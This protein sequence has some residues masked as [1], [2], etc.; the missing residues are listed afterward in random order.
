MMTDKLR[1]RAA[2]Y[3]SDAFKTFLRSDLRITTTKQSGVYDVTETPTTPA[4]H[5]PPGAL[6]RGTGA[7]EKDKKN[8]PGDNPYCRNC[9]EKH[10][11]GAHTKPR[12]TSW[13]P[14]RQQPAE[15]A[16]D[17]PGSPNDASP[18]RTEPELLGDGAGPAP[19][20]ATRTMSD[21]TRL[22]FN[23]YKKRRDN[24]QC[25]RCGEA[26]HLIKECPKP[27]K[28]QTIEREVLSRIFT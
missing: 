16:E 26:G 1:S 2:E 23:A 17:T 7:L 19:A 13:T 10:P 20:H 6:K 15:G 21:I 4:K 3:T 11:Y 27:A 28:D 5:H 25:L 24:G 18:R 22:H 14:L 8:K 12:P 9:G